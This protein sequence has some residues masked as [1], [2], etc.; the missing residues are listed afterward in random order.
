[1]SARILIDPVASPYLVP[2]DGSFRIAAA[3][4][5]PPAGAPKKKA[6]EEALAGSIERLDVL[7]RALY[8]ANRTSLLLVFQAMDAAGK[9]GTIRAVLRGVNPAGCQVYS[10]KAPTSE[11]LEHDFLWRIQRALPERGRIGIFN[12]SHYE[13]VL[14]VKV[15]PSLLAAQQLP[16]RELSLDALWAERYE[17]IRD[18]ERHWARNGVAIVKFFLHVSRD[19][20]KRRFLD[21][22]DNADDNWKF[23][24]AD[25]EVRGQWDRYQAAYEAALRETSRPWAPWY[26]IPAD[27]KSYMRRTVADVVVRTLDALA[28]RFPEVSEAERKELARLRAELEKEG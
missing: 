18:A 14:V 5:E 11:D 26:A 12:R 8:A 25:L 15:N 17:S 27:S 16:Q 19:E 6:N 10:F 20:Q 28:P 4:T 9:D 23:S 22:I 1:M 24:A 7:Q 2:F 13:E 21:R 3:A